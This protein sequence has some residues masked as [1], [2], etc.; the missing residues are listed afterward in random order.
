MRLVLDLVDNLRAI[1]LAARAV[2]E[3]RNTLRQYLPPQPVEDVRYRLTQAKRSDVAGSVRAFGTPS[4]QIRRPGVTELRGGLPAVSAIETLTE[5][6]LLRARIMAGLDVTGELG[7]S[8]AASSASTALAVDN[9]YELLRGSLLSSGILAVDNGEVIQSADFGVKARNRFTTA[10]SWTQ[11]ETAP[12]FTD[13]RTW[14]QRFLRSAG[15]PAGVIVTTLEVQ[16]LILLNRQVRELT[17][18]GGVTP[19]IA[20]PALVASRFAVFGIPPITTNERIID[21]QRVWPEGRLSFLPGPDAAYVGHTLLG[22]PEQSVQLVTASIFDAAEA[23]G[24]SVVTLIED[25]PIARHVN[26][27]S[28]GLPAIETPEAIVVAK[29]MTDAEITDKTAAAVEDDD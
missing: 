11:T 28:I 15:G 13:L 12:I 5:G 23:P 20:D 3:P 22:I 18:V 1:N 9:T 26:A 14:A 16:N 17:A 7:R 6:D 24:V 10:V 2:L 8:V 19:A 21:G 4:R 29:V 27:D 25:H